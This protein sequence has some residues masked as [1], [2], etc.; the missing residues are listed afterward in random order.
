MDVREEFM[1]RFAGIEELET[2]EAQEPNRETEI[3]NSI[4]QAVY[5]ILAAS[6]VNEKMKIEKSVYYPV[7]LNTPGE[8]HDKLKVTRED[9]L[10]AIRVELD[11][12]FLII[13]AADA[14]DLL[15]NRKKNLVG[16]LLAQEVADGELLD[17]QTARLKSDIAEF[18]KTQ[19]S[20]FI[21]SRNIKIY[22]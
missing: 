16:N 4:K 19:Y 14:I 5:D 17:A 9:I 1:G 11:E 10:L 22:V 3:I 21:G 12:R 20:E 13:N 7:V 2:Q 18:F 15:N 8:A 6:E